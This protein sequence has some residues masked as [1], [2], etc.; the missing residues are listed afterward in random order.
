MVPQ[1]G[2]SYLFSN[3]NGEFFVSKQDPK[4]PLIEKCLE[5][6]INSDKIAV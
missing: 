2:V 1:G 6:V 3:A 5:N 4:I